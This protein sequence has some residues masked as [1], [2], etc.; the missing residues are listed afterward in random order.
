[1]LP[2]RWLPLASADSS[3]VACT[4]CAWAALGCQTENEASRRSPGADALKAARRFIVRYC[5]SMR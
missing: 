1:V 2:W 5:I 4:A 3:G